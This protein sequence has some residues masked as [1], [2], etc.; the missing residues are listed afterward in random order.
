VFM[1]HAKQRKISVW[2][3]D[4]GAEPNGGRNTSYRRHLRAGRE[5]KCTR[6]G[7]EER[8][9]QE[10]LSMEGVAEFGERQSSANPLGTKKRN[11]CFGGVIRARKSKNGSEALGCIV[12]GSAG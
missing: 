1:I 3:T 4:R 10:N 5:E 8:L 9:E 2:V 6:N 7:G 12:G 11:T